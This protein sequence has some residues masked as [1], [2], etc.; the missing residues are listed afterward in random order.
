MA[1]DEGRKAMIL[2]T[3]RFSHIAGGEFFFVGGKTGLQ[4][5]NEQSRYATYGVKLRG[6]TED[7]QC[8]FLLDLA[9][10]LGDDGARHEGISIPRTILPRAPQ[11]PR[12]ACFTWGLARRLS[13]VP[14][15][16]IR[17]FTST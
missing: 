13:R 4:G 16:T 12:Y 17:P 9:E 6:T 7:E 3:R 8:E 14:S 1:N 11:R 5:M 2:V 15:S 10:R